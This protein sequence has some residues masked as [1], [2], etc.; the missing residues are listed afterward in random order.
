MEIRRLHAVDAPAARE[1]ART[2]VAGTPLVE[3]SLHALERALGGDDAEAWGL[4]AIRGDELVG[5]VLLGLVAGAQRAGR[6]HLVVVTASAR[7]AGVGRSLLDRAAQDAASRGARFLLA[8]IPEDPALAPGHELLRRAGFRVESRIPDF[9]RE[10]IGI[11]FVR[12]E[13]A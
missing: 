13:L 2:E 8:E 3:A 6:L 5:L 4:V 9:V 10:G 12:R 7:L 11:A 1:L